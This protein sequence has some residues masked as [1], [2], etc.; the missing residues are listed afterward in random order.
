M[1]SILL[2]CV[3]LVAQSSQAATWYV[4][5]DPPHPGDGSKN[6]PFAT[7]QE[8]EAH[9]GAGDTIFIVQSQG[10]LD[11]GIQLKDGQRLIGLGPNVTLA[12]PHSAR[13]MITNS[14][15]ARYDGDAIRLA[16]NNL[17]ENVHID[18]A[19][20]SSILGI[21]AAGAQLHGNLMTNDMAVHSIFDIEGPAPSRCAVANNVPT[22]VGQ[23]PNGYIIFAPQTNH[24]GA[25]T[26]VSCG[27]AARSPLAN[28]DVRPEGYCKFLD[29]ALSGAAASIADT[30][31]VVLDGNVI[32]DSNSDGIMLIDDLGVV[33]HFEIT[34]NVVR[35]LSQ[36]LPD[37]AAVGITDHVV[38]SRGFT[39]ISIDQSVS[40]VA[41]SGYV[42]S[43]LS[44]FGN[45]AADG[46][47]VLT[48]GAGPTAGS[49]GPVI[50]AAISDIAISNPFLTGDTSNGD[51]IE[52]QHR[53]STNGV[54]NVDI[55]R[56]DLRDPAST[57]IK[58]IESTNPAKGI[59]NV[60]LS[61]SVLTNI[62]THGTED[63]QI[64][65]N[66]S[67]TTS[68]T[69][70]L[71]L[72]VRN[73]RMSGLGRGIGLTV[74]P[75]ATTP[76]AA[77]NFVLRQLHILV[78]N[79]SLSDLTREAVEWSQAAGRAIGE[80][81]GA[82]IDL[83]GGPLGSAGN[84]RFVNNGAPGYVPPGADPSGIEPIAMVDGDI[85][86]QNANPAPSPAINIYAS[87]DYWGGGAPNVSSTPGG[88]TDV[89]IAAGTN[90]TFTSTS[91]LTT[92]PQP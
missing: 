20:R 28:V 15:G 23:W 75:N 88:T 57:N 47:V 86:V 58:L 19:F 73:V 64:R 27:S 79:S 30:G 77:N 34:N 43:N 74:P 40:T 71:N 90:V 51:S 91:F 63:T 14:S 10:I 54:L 33:A 49:P 4:K 89:Y 65:Y 18:H 48:S 6:R 55:T 67:S 22:C 26:L 7:L 11:G 82:I 87:N 59:F 52:I 66:A 60:S 31:S 69:D 78:E 35:D 61:D 46:I 39:L 80:T 84:N 38:R 32:R 12:D 8:A 21:N 1:R 85:S 3:L 53:G 16:K 42:G 92:D 45:F 72:T 17:V 5:A 2:A 56:A 24:F 25:I 81:G 76:Q 41:L 70:A 68:G 83:G 50:N 9:S 37:P 36:P 62:N 29:P 13:A 44:P